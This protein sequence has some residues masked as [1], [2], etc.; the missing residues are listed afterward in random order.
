[1][2]FSLAHVPP[3]RMEKTIPNTMR[4]MKANGV[5][6]QKDQMHVGI[7]FQC[8]NGGVRMVDADA[9]STLPGV[10]VIG[11]LAGGVRGPDRPGGNSLAEGQVFGH[12]A[13]D[14]AARDA[15]ERDTNGKPV[16]DAAIARLQLR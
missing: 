16:G 14:A 5:D 2:L 11:E 3:E 7:A 9:R 13:G 12:R 8:L 10:H 6:P 4:W 15:R 1:V